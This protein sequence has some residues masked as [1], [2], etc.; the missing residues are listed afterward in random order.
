MSRD[1]DTDPCLD[2]DKLVTACG[3][4]RAGAE[5]IVD[6]IGPATPGHEGTAMGGRGVRHLFV[7]PNDGGSRWRYAATEALGAPGPRR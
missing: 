5:E 2:F 6:M 4:G 7:N 3:E 1:T